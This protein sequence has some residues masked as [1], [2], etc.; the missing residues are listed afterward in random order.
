MSTG[1]STDF[2]MLESEVQLGCGFMMVAVST[3]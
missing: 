1:K 2:V 3:T